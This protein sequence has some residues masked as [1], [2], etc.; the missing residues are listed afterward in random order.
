M[1]VCSAIL[2]LALFAAGCSEDVARPDIAAQ[3]K[4]DLYGAAIKMQ[5]YEFRA[6]VRKR[7]AAA[8]KQELPALLENL[9]GFEKQPLGTHKETYQQ[10]MDK[11]KALQTA[12]A[13]SA[14]K[15]SAITAANEI[16]TL[17][18]KLP[19]KANENPVVE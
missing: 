5:L 1:R 3:P 10:I 13:G 17:A 9:Q 18:D 4:E 6:K 14:T 19:G 2:V 8:A 7:G 12:V 16:G 15:D 11:L